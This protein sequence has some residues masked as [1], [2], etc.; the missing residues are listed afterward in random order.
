LQRCRVKQSNPRQKTML[1]LTLPPSTPAA[2][3]AFVP[4][5]FAPFYPFADPINGFKPVAVALAE[6]STQLTT[7]PL[8]L[9][10]CE[11]SQVDHLLQFDF[12]A[13]P[14]FT[15]IQ[16]QYQTWGIELAA[17]AI[18]P[19]NPA[20]LNQADRSHSGGLMPALEQ[21]PLTIQ[22]HQTRRLVSLTLLTVKQLIVRAYDA[23]N[24]L[25]AEQ[26]VGQLQSCFTNRDSVHL[27]ACHQIHL[28]GEAVA[29]VEILSS[30]PFL[31]RSLICG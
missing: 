18:Q 15:Q 5:E 19:S 13:L 17:I 12:S 9:A 31:L 20:F 22:F 30:S 7:H 24:R 4:V 14:S 2:Y 28:Q 21:Q 16:Q 26:Q 8:S 29:R 1:P 6:A 3:P 27:S 10:A 23:A 11:A 25:I